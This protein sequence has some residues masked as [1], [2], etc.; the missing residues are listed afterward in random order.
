MRMRRNIKLNYY[1]FSLAGHV[2][3]VLGLI[4]YIAM[5]APQ[6]LLGDDKTQFVNS[7]IYQGTVARLQETQKQS[8]QKILKQQAVA[9]APSKIHA[10]ALPKKTEAATVVE[11]NL[12]DPSAP[13]ASSQGQEANALL[14]ML[15]KAI[16][17]RQQYP[18]S[19]QQLERTGR[20]KVK[21]TLFPNGVVH[22]I[23]MIQ[24][25]GTESLDKA[26]LKAINDAAPFKGVNQYI[27]ESQEFSIDVVFD[28]S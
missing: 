26:A 25:S 9:E 16:Q 23:Q 14:S 3:L 7:Y 27:R 12:L 19:A 5:P 8:A 11:K 28:L 22:A 2:V 21:F 6:Y 10:L 1:L 17:N 15:H 18:L 4:F 13:A 20:V 24:S